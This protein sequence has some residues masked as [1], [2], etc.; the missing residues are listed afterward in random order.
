MDEPARNEIAADES[1]RDQP[2]DPGEAAFAAPD[3]PTLDEAASN[4]AGTDRARPGTDDIAFERIDWDEVAPGRRRPWDE[5]DR[6]SWRHR[7]RRHAPWIVAALVLVVL[8]V[9]RDPLAD[10]LWPET[11]AQKLLQRADTALAAGRLSA[12]DG[13]GAR[14]LYEAA[15]ALDPDR[16]DARA[17]LSLVGEAAITQARLAIARRQFDAARR[18]LALASELSV[19]RARID[20]LRE[21][22][23][24]NESASVPVDDLLARAIAARAEGRLD[25]SDDSA[26]RLF[27]RVLELQPDRTE[28]LEGREDT[29]ADLLQQSRA[30]IEDGD[31]AAAMAIVKRVREADA[32]HVGLP[33]AIAAL[34]QGAERERDRASRALRRG[35]LDEAREGFGRA[36]LVDAADAEALRGLVAVATAHA[37][38]ADR[39]A[40]DYRFEEADAEL[41]L[42]SDVAKQSASD[43]PAIADAQRHLERARQ[44]RR[45]AGRGSS[46][47]QQRLEVRRLLAEA[48]QAEARGDLLT[49]PGESAFDRLRAARALAPRDPSVRSASQR[50]AARAVQCHAAALHGNRLETAG[51]CLDL[52]RA[53]EGD[54]PAVRAARRELARRW[55]AMGDQRLGAGELQGAR[56]ALAAARALDPGAEGLADFAERVRTA[57]TA[58]EAAER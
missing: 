55:I 50:L 49:P 25:G 41:R 13:S 47:A 3:E 43:V 58:I 23:R 46:P 5:P 26:L 11:R 56:S 51:N 53:L 12:A 44:A 14:E 4:D 37:R 2:V 27:Q 19:P 40:A 6:P 31:L 10:R 36:L 29:L 17:G 42:A 28:A 18:H 30:R 45:Q 9:F 39:L 48:A 21:Q 52:R 38:R 1:G 20:G 34:G 35:R 54:T 32:G 57:T 15:L 33:D 24:V 8:L 22:L 7:M 16:P